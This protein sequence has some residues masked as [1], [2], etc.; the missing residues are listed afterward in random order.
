MQCKYSG[1]DH[2]VWGGDFNA[3]IGRVGQELRGIECADKTC[4]AR[5]K[6][7]ANFVRDTGYIKANGNYGPNDCTFER[8]S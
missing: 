4:N 3:R 8:G 1:C 2:I 5:G 7:L 6:A